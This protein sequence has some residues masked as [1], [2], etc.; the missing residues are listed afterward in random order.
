MLLKLLIS[1]IRFPSM[2]AST[3]LFL[4]VEQLDTGWRLWHYF[5]FF[6]PNFILVSIIQ[7]DLGHA[8]ILVGCSMLT[9]AI[10]RLWASGLNADSDRL[11]PLSLHDRSAAVRRWFVSDSSHDCVFL[12]EFFHVG[13]WQLFL[14]L[15]LHSELKGHGINL[16]S[17]SCVVVL[18]IP[19]ICSV[20]INHAWHCSRKLWP[21]PIYSH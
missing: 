2:L 16:Y 5:S 12:I 6:L 4:L 18:N 21:I 3:P 1:E 9:L 10:F 7:L 15:T 11:S 20:L 19:Y 8:L 17:L 13:I 14:A